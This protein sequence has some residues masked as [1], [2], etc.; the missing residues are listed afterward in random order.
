MALSVLIYKTK[1]SFHSGVPGYP[2]VL[3]RTANGFSLERFKIEA[4]EPMWREGDLNHINCKC[5]AC[6][7]LN[8]YKVWFTTFNVTWKNHQV[9]I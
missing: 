2:N 3:F 9:K 8:I 7:N 4:F 1:A 5:G 6:K